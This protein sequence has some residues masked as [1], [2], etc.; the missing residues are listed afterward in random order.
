VTRGPQ[1]RWDDDFP[2]LKQEGWAGCATAGWPPASPDYSL[3][4]GVLCHTWGQR[5]LSSSFCWYLI[6]PTSDCS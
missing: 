3:C 5:V 4:A 2:E 6:K 1:E